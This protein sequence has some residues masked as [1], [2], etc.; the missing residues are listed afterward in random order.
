[1]KHGTVMA[2]TKRRNRTLPVR[3]APAELIPADPKRC[4]A[5]V[6]NGHSFMT[7]GGVPGR[8]R[9]NNE[10]AMIINERIASTDGRRGSM[11]LCERC[12]T[13][14]RVQMPNANVSVVLLGGE[15]RARR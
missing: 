10:P 6:P 9:C 3:K 2:T 14:F 7:L 5:E 15:N 8:V 4:Q 12:F 1:M 11:S 13:V